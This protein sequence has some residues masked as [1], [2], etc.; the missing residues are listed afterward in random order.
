M[1]FAHL[2]SQRAWA[3]LG[4]LINIKLHKKYEQ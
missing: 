4:R 2:I 3:F 1:V